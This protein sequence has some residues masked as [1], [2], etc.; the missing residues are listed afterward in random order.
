MKIG[1]QTWGSTG[2]INPFIALAAGLVKAGH[3]VTLVITGAERRDYA[4]TGARLGFRVVQAGHIGESEQALNDIGR[5]LFAIGNPVAQLRFIF[6]QMF[7][8]GVA[9][10]YAAAQTLSADHDLIV[11]HFIVHPAQLAAEQAG[12][13]YVTVALNQ[14]GIPTR[15]V[16]PS[17]L[18][19]LGHWCNGMLWKLAEKMINGMVL[20]SANSLRI[21]HG[22]HPLTSYR[23]IWESAACNLIA[24]SP[25]LCPQY[26]DWGEN[27]RVC[28]FLN[29]PEEASD[30]RM[31]DDLARFLQNGEAP[32]Y[33]G[34]GSMIG[35]ALPNADLDDA[36][37][38]MLG[39]VKL[40]G[41]RAIVQSHWDVVNTMPEDAQ[42]YRLSSA[43]HTQIF[44]LCA[45]I[46]H[47]GGAGTT[48]TALR[49]ARPSVVV[50]HITDQFFWG[51]TLRKLG[52]APAVLNRRKTTPAKLAAA[53]RA[54][55]ASPAMRFAAEEAGRKLQAE[56][57]A[58]AAAR[59]IETRF[60]HQRSQPLRFIP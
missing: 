42:I 57:G 17:P 41:C 18:P 52:V 39:A 6:E 8:P 49:C 10:M 27:Q 13:P 48:Q 35:L 29:V 59:I 12:K 47:H 55:L 54:V 28:G 43:P 24:V 3:A 30:W 32:V 34:F 4:E 26:P 22:S 14:G 2:D 40:A 19:N 9:A 60:G 25:V 16:P 7:D 38:L 1:I 11:G 21:A 53:I 5:R 44:P 23:Q 33:I 15:Y 46:V 37:R 56:N 50:A 45:A 36:T 51:D 58:A 20:P 31:P